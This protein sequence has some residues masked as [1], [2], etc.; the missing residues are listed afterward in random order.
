MEATEHKDYVVR[1]NDKGCLKKS[2]HWKE[3]AKYYLYF[4]RLGPGDHNAGR[5]EI[6]DTVK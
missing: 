2:P 3:S 1:K 5:N 6:D 4:T